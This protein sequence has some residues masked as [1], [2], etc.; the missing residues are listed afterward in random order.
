VAS[1]ADE[2]VQT[3]GDPGG[4]PIFF[5]HGWQLEKGLE[6]ADFEPAMRG[7]PGWRR[8][9]TDLP[10]MGARADEGR[11]IRSFTRLL[12]WVIDFVEEQAPDKQFAI[13]GMS[14][15]AELARGVVDRMPE[16]CLGLLIRVPRLIADRT[17]RS[18]HDKKN[19]PPEVK[20]DADRVKRDAFFDRDNLGAAM[21]D[22]F[23]IENDERHE[24][25]LQ[26]RKRANLDVLKTIEAHYELRPRPR[27]IFEK[28]SLIIV[29][30][31]DTRVGFLEA[32]ETGK[33]IRPAV[34]I[35]LHKQYPRA[36]IAVL[37]RAGHA[38]PVGSPALFH[39]LV[40]DWVERMEEVI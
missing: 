10:G 3:F 29:G 8:I 13:A 2:K 32:L 28:P 31:Q 40:R 38:L 15:G 35:A 25:W 33:E 18:S 5:L 14:V 17:L 39:A 1:R 27:K 19:L 22:L 21:P 20:T 34:G 4:R 37:D 30:R 26:A 12:G 16:R 36:T 9:Y 7:R 23:E 11:E 6:I 24:S